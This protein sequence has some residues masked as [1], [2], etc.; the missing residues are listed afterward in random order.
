MQAKN[1]W[2]KALGCRVTRQVASATCILC[3]GFAATPDLQQFKRR[4]RYRSLLSVAQRQTKTPGFTSASPARTQKKSATWDAGFL[5]NS[6]WTLAT[7]CSLCCPVRAGNLSKFP[8]AGSKRAESGYRKFRTCR[9]KDDMGTCRG[10]RFSTS[11][12]DCESQQ[13]PISIARRINFCPAFC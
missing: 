8:A 10:S 5:I 2:I 3:S 12:G 13:S 11:T 6:G 1:R 4:A 7:V 9:S